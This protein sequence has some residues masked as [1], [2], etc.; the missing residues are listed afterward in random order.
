MKTRMNLTTCGKI[1]MHLSKIRIHLS[2]RLWLH[3][4]EEA[5][6]VEVAHH[7]LH[8]G[9][10]QREARRH[11]AAAHDAHCILDACRKFSGC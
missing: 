9:A 10:A 2:G 11:G 1:R 6:V 5:A 4:D 3:L 7:R 8:G